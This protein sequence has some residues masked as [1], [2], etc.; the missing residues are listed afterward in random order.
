MALRCYGK[1]LSQGTCKSKECGPNERQDLEG[2]GM[3]QE[4]KARNKIN[5][6]SEIRREMILHKDA[7]DPCT[8][9]TNCQK[10][11]DEGFSVL[12]RGQ[13]EKKIRL[14]EEDTE[15]SQTE[16]TQPEAPAAVDTDM[17]KII[18]NG[19][20][21]GAMIGLSK[22]L[23]KAAWTGEVDELAIMKDVAMVGITILSI[24]NP[25]AGLVCGMLFGFIQG[26]FG[27]A[28]QESADQQLY[29][30]LQERMNVKIDINNL[31]NALQD[32]ATA[33]KLW[34]RSL[35]T[36]T[37]SANDP[38]LLKAVKN[39]LYLQTM[40]VGLQLRDSQHLDDEEWASNM[41]T[42]FLQV[43]MAEM[44]LIKEAHPNR[45]LD[46]V[47]NEIKNHF[48]TRDDSYHKAWLKMRRPAIEG[49]KKRFLSQVN[50]KTH[51]DST[52]WFL[53]GKECWLTMSYDSTMYKGMD[54]A[55]I[56][57]CRIG[58]HYCDLPGGS[59]CDRCWR[60]APDDLC[61]PNHAEVFYHQYIQTGQI[62]RMETEHYSLLNNFLEAEGLP[63]KAP[64]STC[65]WKS[66]Y[67]CSGRTYSSF[68]LDKAQC[69]KKCTENS[70]CNCVT[71]SKDWAKPCRLESGEATN[72]E[73]P[74]YSALDKKDFT[75]CQAFNIGR[76]IWSGHPVCMDVSGLKT[77]NGANVAVWE[78]PDEWD[79]SYYK[80]IV[81]K[82]GS[83]LIKW[84]KHPNKCLDVLDGGGNLG[85]WDCGKNNANQQWIIPP[86]GTGNIQWAAHPNKCIN[87]KNGVKANGVDVNMGE[88]DGGVPQEW[89]ILNE[90]P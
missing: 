42:F 72:R 82:S 10:H 44:S 89:N 68:G 74:A 54:I 88:C 71:Y 60:T 17:K 41:Y 14:M 48:V 4:T 29:R 55:K 79:L 8:P 47:R 53:G 11:K 61:N 33:A 80:W 5:G 52:Q 30:L 32:M 36:L 9:G 23:G 24:F 39:D 73:N 34:A 25:A 87:V 40:E 1:N 59:N 64:A 75:T 65:S 6:S 46:S 77:T 26:F 49:A 20:F 70:N 22:T 45:S 69:V 83:G 38:Q 67:A 81:P 19:P 12:Q 3:L 78:C 86:T 31:R 84:L 57:G 66:G 50:W 13:V 51:T 7:A 28:A 90:G 58:E 76:I 2:I 43:E 63:S 18:K 56:M 85:I 21:N 27:A 62:G 16:A 35:K 37:Y 15:E